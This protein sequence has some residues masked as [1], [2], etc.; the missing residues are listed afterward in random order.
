[1]GWGSGVD[2]KQDLPQHLAV[3]CS[4]NKVLTLWKFFLSGGPAPDWLATSN[5]EALPFEISK[6]LENSPLPG[7]QISSRA[8]F[9]VNGQ[10]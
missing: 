8:A 2:R 3:D 5:P 6:A 1:M 4:E 7:P 9:A 10:I